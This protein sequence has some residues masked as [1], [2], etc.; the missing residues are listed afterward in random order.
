MTSNHPHA[1][2]NNQIVGDYR[3][4]ST[5]VG[6]ERYCMVR[7]GDELQRIIKISRPGEGDNIRVWSNETP[8]T[9]EM[10]NILKH[11]KRPVS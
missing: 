9:L 5:V 2:P 6:G 11:E 1:N 8:I 4:S 7:N 3:Y 10:L